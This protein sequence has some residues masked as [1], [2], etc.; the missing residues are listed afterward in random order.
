MGN[1]ELELPWKEGEYIDFANTTYIEDGVDSVVANASPDYT[2][3]IVTAVNS[4][5]DLIEALED[6]KAMDKHQPVDY[7]KD[8]E[9]AINLIKSMMAH[10][11]A[12]L[13]KAR[14][15]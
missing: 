1:N 10:A 9:F 12:A 8:H 2:K 7:L 6:V 5:N 14:G 11:E 15:E 3:L 13:T 4:H